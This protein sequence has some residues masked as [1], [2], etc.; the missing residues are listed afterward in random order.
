MIISFLSKI[1]TTVFYFLAYEVLTAITTLA[2][3]KMHTLNVWFSSVQLL[4]HVPL[5][6]TP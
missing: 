3:I 1:I 5:F 4:S 2:G 6:A